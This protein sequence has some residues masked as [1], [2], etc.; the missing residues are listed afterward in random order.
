[1]VIVHY[2]EPC[3]TTGRT[4][5]RYICNLLLLDMRL[6]L[7]SFLFA[8]LRRLLKTKLFFVYNCVR[9]ES[10]LLISQTGI[11]AVGVFKKRL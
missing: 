5:V 7:T 4:N 1:M 6:L 11:C 8:L 10:F 3:L 2:S 9:W